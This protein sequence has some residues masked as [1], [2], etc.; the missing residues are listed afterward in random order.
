M[1]DQQPQRR[2]AYEALL[3]RLRALLEGETDV[4][5]VMST[6]SCEL[7]QAM[8]S[9]HWVGFYRNVG[10]DMLKVGPYQG[11]HGCLSIT[12][13][14]GICGRCATTREVQLVADVNAEPDHIACAHTTRSEIVLPVFNRSGEL[15]AVFDI[16]SD[17]PDNFSEL[18]ARYLS[19]ILDV[20]KT[21]P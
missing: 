5:A 9:F 17:M 3:P 20:F 21:L 7:I 12:F 2:Q 6:L 8:D 16:D 14:R 11:G 4:I 1:P 18:D 19:S 10:N 15:I 13:D